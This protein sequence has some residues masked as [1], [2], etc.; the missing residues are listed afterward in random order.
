M[1][2][3]T[4]F[5]KTSPEEYRFLDF[6]KYRQGQEDFTFSFQKEANIL[7]KSLDLILNGSKEAKNNANRLKQSFEA[8][9]TAE[10]LIEIENN[11]VDTT[12]KTKEKELHLAEIGAACSVMNSTTTVLQSAIERVDI[13]LKGAGK[14][15]P[16]LVNNDCTKKIKHIED[17]PTSANNELEYDYEETDTDVPY[18]VDEANE[19]KCLTE[20]EIIIRGQ[21]LTILNLIKKDDVNLGKTYMTSVCLNQIIDFSDVEIKKLIEKYLNNE[22]QEWLYSVLMKK[23]WNPS[24][25]YKQYIEQFKEGMCN[26]TQVP[27][28]VRKTFVE[29]RFDPYFNEGH[30]IVQHIFTHWIEITTP[31]TKKRKFDGVLKIERGKGRIIIAIIEFSKGIQASLTKKVD[32]HVKLCRN[33][34]RNL[35][36][37]LQS[38]S[39]EKARIYLIQ[40][41]NGYI[42]VEYLM[43]PLPGVYILDKFTEIK[44][45]E[46]FDEFE[47]FAEKFTELMNFQADILSTVRSVNKSIQ[48]KENIHIFTTSVKDTPQKDPPKKQEISEYQPSSPRSPC[49]GDSES[50]LI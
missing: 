40:S 49:P 46:S 42:K 5:D 28:L 38:V 36:C 15:P 48:T 34:M 25:D 8:N 44:I 10:T 1:S 16:E 30:D 37:L 11:L 2:W 39:K 3:D 35:N 6:Y 26:R 7:R 33:A 32:D 27:I 45:P 31:S 23:V 9:I 21:L 43:R 22:Q 13:T 14:R 47:A 12:I 24:D 17:S 41:A 4:Y 50:P 18:D 20:G 29:G 19:I